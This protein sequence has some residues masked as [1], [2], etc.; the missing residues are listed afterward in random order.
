MKTSR[1]PLTADQQNLAER[2]I[3]LALSLAKPFKRSFPHDADEYES[4]AR[5]AV[6]TAAQ[7]FDPEM[8]VKFATFARKRIRFA[9]TDVQRLATAKGWCDDPEHG[10]RFIPLEPWAED[11]G[12]VLFASPHLPVEHQV[13]CND[14]LESWLKRLP[15]RLAHVCRVIDL[16]GK[17][18]AETARLMGCSKSRVCIL[19]SEAIERLREMARFEAEAEEFRK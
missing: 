10:P 3:P 17:T 15:A 7:A 9:M 11:F 6:V 8:G 19:H 1:P 2:Y 16:E 13:A 4:A 14:Q 5:M 18:H 12:Q